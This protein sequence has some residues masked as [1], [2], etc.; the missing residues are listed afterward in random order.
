[1]DCMHIC[2]QATSILSFISGYDLKSELYDGR[3]TAKE[4]QLKLQINIYLC[5]IS[6]AD[7]FL[8]LCPA[9]DVVE[10]EEAEKGR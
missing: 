10:V 1:M 2:I 4:K 9:H 6:L 7:M 8:S 5:E 3:W